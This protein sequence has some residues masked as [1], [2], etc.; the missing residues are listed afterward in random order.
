[1]CAKDTDQDGISD[2]D[3]DSDNDGITDAVKLK[4]VILLL[5]QLLI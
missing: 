3:V 2:L 4:E 5:T 1:L